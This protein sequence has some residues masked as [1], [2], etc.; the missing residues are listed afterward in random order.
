MEALCANPAASGASASGTCSRLE[1]SFA[2]HLARGSWA[3]SAVAQAQ[4]DLPR[5][6][7][8]PHLARKAV[9]REAAAHLTRPERE[10][11]EVLVTELVTNA[12]THPGVQAGETVSLHLAVAPERIR[13]EVCD[14]GQGF[15]T[16][17]LTRPRDEPGGYGLVMVNRGASRWGASQDDGN[18]VWFELNRT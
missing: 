18:C 13:V 14:G 12:V 6:I 17:Q 2:Y 1:P 15:T 4:V 5:G 16:A 11:V 8:A 9:Q 7:E 3:P 10:I